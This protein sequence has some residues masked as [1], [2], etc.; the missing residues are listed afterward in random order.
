M[1]RCNFAQQRRLG[2]AARHRV[3]AASVE[4]AAGRR[5]DRA[6]HGCSTDGACGLARHERDAG[7]ILLYG[8]T[9]IV[10]ATPAEA[11]DRG[12]RAKRAKA[13]TRNENGLTEKQQAR[14]DA[15][16]ECKSSLHKRTCPL[17]VK[18]TYKTPKWAAKTWHA[19]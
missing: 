3:G 12:T 4:V 10:V 17:Y 9:P 16:C 7:G 14:R 2:L 5:I 1:P 13:A 11:S 6:R 8:V 18:Q 19:N 15:G